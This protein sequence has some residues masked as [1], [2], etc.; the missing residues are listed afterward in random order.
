[1][2][3]DCH[4]LAGLG[5]SPVSWFPR[6]EIEG[7]IWKGRWRN[8]ERDEGYPPRGRIEGMLREMAAQG[9]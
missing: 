6:G 7:L 5:D 4:C 3:A 1:M 2:D 8:I 9:T